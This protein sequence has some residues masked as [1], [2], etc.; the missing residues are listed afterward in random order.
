MTAEDELLESVLSTVILG[1]VLFAATNID[2]VFILLGFFADRTFRVRDVVLGQYLGI[3]VL[4]GASLAA[5]MLAL[6]VPLQ[7][8]GWLGLI[9]IALGVKKLYDHWRS[10]DEDDSAGH[11]AASSAFR[12]VMSVAA[13]TVAN[14]GDNIGVYTPVFAVHSAAEICAVL[15]VFAVMTGIWCGI[16]HWMVNHRTLGAPIRRYAQALMPLVLIAIGVWVIYEA[17]SLQVLM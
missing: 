13:V 15:V 11:G 3:I 14:G 5:A 2:D 8:I 9:P 4:V 6:I 16:A 1:I 17:G 10:V 7:Y 12:R